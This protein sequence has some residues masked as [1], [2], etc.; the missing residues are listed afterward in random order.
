ML[1]LL[2]VT[3]YRQDLKDVNQVSAQKYFVT[4]H[5]LQPSTVGQK[6]QLYAMS[7]WLFNTLSYLNVGIS[8]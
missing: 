1:I 7:H 2:H 4:S 8:P 6:C 5:V 3:V